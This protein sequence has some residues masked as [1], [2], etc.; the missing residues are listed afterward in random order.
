MCAGIKA[1]RRRERPPYGACVEAAQ[2]V[3][4]VRM[5]RSCGRSVPKENASKENALK[6]NTLK[7]ALKGS[8]LKESESKGSTSRGK[9]ECIEWERVEGWCIEGGST[10]SRGGTMLRYSEE[11]M[12]PRSS[13]MYLTSAHCTGLNSIPSPPVVLSALIVV[14]LCLAGAGE[15]RVGVP[16]C[17][18]ARVGDAVKGRARWSLSVGDMWLM[19]SCTKDHGQKVVDDAVS[20]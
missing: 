17:L 7:G 8:A 9:R 4:Q 20:L 14:G 15:W 10:L 11:G 18:G 12:Q 16:L 6:G 3:L 5:C 19:K 1:A 13:R 2:G